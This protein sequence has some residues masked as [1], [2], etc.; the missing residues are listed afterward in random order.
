MHL[1]RFKINSVF[2]LYDK[3]NKLDIIVTSYNTKLFEQN[4]FYNSVL[5]YNKLSHVI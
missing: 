2:H 1:S 3:R 5:I 4:I